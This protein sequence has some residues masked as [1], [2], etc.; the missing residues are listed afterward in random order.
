[1][2]KVTSETLLDAA[3]TYIDL[4]TARTG[5]A[6]ALES[7]E[8]LQNLLT[9]AKGLAEV[10]PGS[11]VEVVRVQLEI[12]SQQQTIRKLREGATAAAAK[13]AYLLGIDPEA[14]LVVVDR[15]M[16]PFDL[17]D[18]NVP[19][20]ELVERALHEGPGIQEMERLLAL[21]QTNAQRARSGAGLWVP[22]VEVKMT[23]GILGGGPGMNTSWDN[24]WNLGLQLRWNLT[25][26]LRQREQQRL[27]HLK[28]HQAHLSYQDLRAKLTLG[29]QEA[30]EAS[31]STHEQ[32]RLCEEQIRQAREANRLSLLRF[33]QPPLKQRAPPSEVMLSIKAL[34]GAQLN[35]LTAIRDH[36]KAQVRLLVLLG[37]VHA[38]PK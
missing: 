15:Q 37:S 17:V 14:E 8:S 7:L 25:E 21:I 27:T 16:V 30:R 12:T 36:D 11:E 4:L 23:E 24:S 6:I 38:C 18:V 31:V 19:I 32:L 22:V 26:H 10:E 2:S 9:K 20:E 13:L 29:V 35:Y 1:L 34:A 5:E 28:M 3:N 33:T